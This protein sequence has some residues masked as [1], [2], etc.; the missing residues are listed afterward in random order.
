M[1]IRTGLLIVVVIII[2]AALGAANTAHILTAIGEW[3]GTFF[4]NLGK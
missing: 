4:S 1:T 3:I 2:L